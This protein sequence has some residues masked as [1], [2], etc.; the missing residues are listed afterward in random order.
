VTA[1]VPWDLPDPFSIE[2]TVP[3]DAIDSY[4]H[5][6]NT[7]YIA[8][9]E[10]CA[11]AHSAAVGYP[12]ERC[13]TLERGMAVRTLGVEYLAACYQG[14]RVLV[15]NWLLS[16]DGRLRA[17]RRFQVINASRDQV[18]LRAE[19]DYVC[20]N[21]RTG[22]PTRMPEGFVAAYQPLDTSRSPDSRA[23]AAPGSGQKT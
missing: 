4:G 17:T 22:R 6:N 2:I 18:A 1:S 7:V 20:V 15:G 23:R 12:E 10:R 16:N 5:V 3:A 8:W 19:V 13:V 14:D 9:L 21:L 11:W